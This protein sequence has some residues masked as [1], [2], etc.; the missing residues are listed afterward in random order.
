MP[1]LAP[2]SRHRELE[3][4]GAFRKLLLIVRAERQDYKINFFQFSYFKSIYRH[5]HKTLGW[6]PSYCH[7]VAPSWIWDVP[8][9]F[10]QQS[11]PGRGPDHP[12]RTIRPRDRW[13]DPACQHGEEDRVQGGV[14]A[15]LC[16]RHLGASPTLK[17]PTGRAWKKYHPYT[18]TWVMVEDLPEAAHLNV[19]MCSEERQR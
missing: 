1:S 6:K 4:S 3:H 16:V 13:V 17:G 8:A 12:R 7:V 9:I 19:C 5:L 18:D 10:E 2:N 15:G 14:H 11:V